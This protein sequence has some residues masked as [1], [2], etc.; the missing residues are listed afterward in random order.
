MSYD[1]NDFCGCREGAPEEPKHVFYAVRNRDGTFY[2]TYSKSGTG[3][4]WVKDLATS[5]VYAKASMARATITRLANEF[6]KLPIPELV[7]FHVTEIRVI[8]QEDRVAESRQ[9]K[10][11][12]DQ[13]RIERNAQ[14]RI[15]LAEESV[16]KAQAELDRLR[17]RR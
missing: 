5:R 15:K 6:P 17:R 16:A 3:R 12:A 14:Y 2:K 4:G 11:I 10:L 9:K 8:P 13:Q 1:N 7:E